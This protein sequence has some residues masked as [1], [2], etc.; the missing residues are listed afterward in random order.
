MKKLLL[1]GIAFGSTLSAQAHDHAGAQ[2]L[3]R[4]VFPV[5]CN[6]EAQ[7]R[8]TTAVAG[9]H[10]FYWEQGDAAFTAVADADSTCAMAY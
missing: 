7:Q 10:S 1:A 9:L 8:F 6:A 5:S 3:G 4:V 2:A